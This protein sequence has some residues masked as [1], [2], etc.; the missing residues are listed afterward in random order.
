MIENATSFK[1][2]KSDFK[3][4]SKKFQRIAI[5]GKGTYGCVYKAHPVGDPEKIVA[6]KKIQLYKEKDGVKITPINSTIFTKR[7]LRRARR[8]P[9]LASLT[10]A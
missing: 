10:P 3:E 9:F 6:L 4:L 1:G 2:W 8:P 5:V 7:L